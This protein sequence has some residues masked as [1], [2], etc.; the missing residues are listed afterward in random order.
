MDALI[1]KD[2]LF[3]NTATVTKD[4]RGIQW[5]NSAMKYT[6]TKKIRVLIDGE[7]EILMQDGDIIEKKDVSKSVEIVGFVE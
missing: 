5:E 1:N 6:G 7:R 3:T 2:I 4:F